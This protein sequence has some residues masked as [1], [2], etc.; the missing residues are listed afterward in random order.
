MFLVA[1]SLHF[2]GDVVSGEVKAGAHVK[3]EQ[4]VRE[5]E[6]VTSLVEQVLAL[7]IP[8]ARQERGLF[9]Q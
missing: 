4:R 3:V 1:G 5:L 2:G 6:L 8:E 7:V 9:Q